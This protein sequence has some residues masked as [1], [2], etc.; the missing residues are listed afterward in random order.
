MTLVFAGLCSHGPGLTGRAD[1]A[2]PNQLT[3]MQDAFDE[4]RRRLEAA[5]PAGL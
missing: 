4:M 1:L 5:R 3:A 2:D